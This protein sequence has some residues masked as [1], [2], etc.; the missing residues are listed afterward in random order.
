MN[1]ID[2]VLSID[3]V[4]ELTEL[5][6]NVKKYASMYYTPNWITKFGVDEIQ[7]YLLQIGELNNNY[8]GDCIPTLTIGDI[9]SILPKI[10]HSYNPMIFV[11]T[12]Y[13]Y[14]KIIYEYSD[15]QQIY[16]ENANK[17]IDIFF[18]TLKWCIINKHL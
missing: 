15:A 14:C 4:Q 3:Q 10:E 13:S 9:L 7:D 11:Y 17:P 16:H 12:G 18:K 2:Q 5:G 1:I 8:K 6:F